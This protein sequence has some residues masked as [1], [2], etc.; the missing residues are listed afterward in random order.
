MHWDADD[1]RVDV[2]DDDARDA[3]RARS[4]GLALEAGHESGPLRFWAPDEAL[5]ST[6]ERTY[7]EPRSRRLLKRIFYRWFVRVADRFAKGFDDDDFL[8]RNGLHPA[9]ELAASDEAS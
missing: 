5:P 9:R 3:A 7:S 4:A 1:W 6:L 8:N 2:V